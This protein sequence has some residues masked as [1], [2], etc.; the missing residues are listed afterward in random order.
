MEAV[1]NLPEDSQIRNSSYFTS[2]NLEKMKQIMYS[3]KFNLDTAVFHEGDAADKLYF[4]LSGRVKVTKFSEEGKEYIMSVYHAGDFFGQL[5][6]FHE[7]KHSFTALTMEKCEIGIIQRSDLEILIWQYGD[8][9]IEFM[10]WMGYMQ[11][12]SQSKFRDLIMY[13]KP[14]ALCSTLIRLSNSYGSVDENGI[15]ISLKLT[16]SELADYIGSARES[17]NRMLGDLKKAGVISMNDG[18][19]TILNLKYLQSVCKCEQCPKE[20]C[21]I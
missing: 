13:G 15:H 1:R 20:L 10:N 21:R 7:S 14:G 19:I 9:A 8:L 17:V 6:P 11:R 2:G 12:L 16:N 4:I 5:D 18:T 3:Y